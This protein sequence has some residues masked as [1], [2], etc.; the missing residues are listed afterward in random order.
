MQFDDDADDDDAG[1]AVIPI[2]VARQIR[3]QFRGSPAGGWQRFGVYSQ[4]V[5]AEACVARLRAGGYSARL[6]DFRR[7]PVAG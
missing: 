2:G 5:Q 1:P 7:T 6:L 3:V 4:R